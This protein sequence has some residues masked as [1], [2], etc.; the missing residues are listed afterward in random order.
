MPKEP[1]VNSGPSATFAV[2]AIPPKKMAVPPSGSSPKLIQRGPVSDP[3]QQQRP[4]AKSVGAQSMNHMRLGSV[5]G[6]PPVP[7]APPK[8]PQVT[9]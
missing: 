5:S 6:P 8:R 3:M 2:P 9:N 1:V 4:L 7:A